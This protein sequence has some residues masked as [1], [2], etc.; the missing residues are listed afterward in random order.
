M[1]DLPKSVMI[2]LLSNSPWITLHILVQYP[3][4]HKPTS[5]IH[6]T[7]KQLLWALA[8][9]WMKNHNFLLN[10]TPTSFICP[11]LTVVLPVPGNNQ[12][13]SSVCDLWFCAFLP[14]FSS[15]SCSYGC[16][17]SKSH[18]FSQSH[19]VYSSLNL[20]QLYSPFGDKKVGKATLPIRYLSEGECCCLWKMLTASQKMSV[21]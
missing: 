17:G 12:C 16:S 20:L 3:F 10:P 19:S 4:Q 11:S 18:H 5:F 2:F 6:N 8:N 7:C 1:K 13:L 21:L 14:Y 15:S 9:C